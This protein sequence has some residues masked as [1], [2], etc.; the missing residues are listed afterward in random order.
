MHFSFFFALLYYRIQWDESVNN[1][2]SRFPALSHFQC[3]S[4][5]TDCD[6]DVAEAA[7]KLAVQSE[8]DDGTSMLPLSSPI[9]PLRR[10]RWAAVGLRAGGS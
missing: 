3:S 8:P 6:G 7:A 5:L 4:A 1:L 9:P 2:A 10:M